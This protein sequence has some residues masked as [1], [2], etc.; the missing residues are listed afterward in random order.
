MR[1]PN[2]EEMALREEVRSSGWMVARDLR[3]WLRLDTN[4]ILKKAVKAGEV[5][6]EATENL[7]RLNPKVKGPR[8]KWGEP[9]MTSGEAQ[10]VLGC[11]RQWMMMLRRGNKIPHVV[12]GARTVRWPRR[13]V[14]EYKL[15][16]DRRKA[17]EAN[18]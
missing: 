16:Y 13:R 9:M 18:A 5:Q 11:S 1:K 8:I 17:Q 14:L 10:A 4:V 2:M 15:E 12:L 6:W 7:W 3:N